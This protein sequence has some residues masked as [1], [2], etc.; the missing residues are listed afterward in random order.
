MKKKSRG[1]VQKKRQKQHP[2]I[3]HI[4]MIIQVSERYKEER[5]KRILKS[6]VK[7]QSKRRPQ[8]P[9]VPHMI[10]QISEKER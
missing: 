10:K 6:G 4:R 7:V 3:P 5:E 1:K 9:S 2:S 8:H